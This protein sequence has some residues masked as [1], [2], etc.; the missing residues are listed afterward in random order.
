ME[1]TA[2]PNGGVTFHYIVPIWLGVQDVHAQWLGG[3]VLRIN[4]IGGVT[5]RVDAQGGSLRV[6]VEGRRLGL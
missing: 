3:G 4:A 6:G 2:H 5:S 1:N